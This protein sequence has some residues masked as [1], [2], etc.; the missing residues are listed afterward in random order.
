MEGTVS[1]RELS[2]TRRQPQPAQD[3]IR[4]VTEPGTEAL[5]SSV[6]GRKRLSASREDLTPS[7]SFQ[8]NAVS[9]YRSPSGVGRSQGR[10]WRCG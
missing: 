1:L 7:L 6:M 8:R 4:L 3:A 9:P 5:S 10:R 2:G